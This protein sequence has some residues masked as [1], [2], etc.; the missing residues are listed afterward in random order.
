MLRHH[1]RPRNAQLT[2]LG[3]QFQWAIYAMI[4]D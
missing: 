2:A 4:F 1:Q 3:D